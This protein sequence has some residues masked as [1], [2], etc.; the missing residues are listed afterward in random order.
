MSPS[1]Y[2]KMTTVGAD[3]R[4]SASPEPPLDATSTS[5]P[6][7]V[8]EATSAARSCASPSTTRMRAIYRSHLFCH[9]ARVL[10]PQR[11]RDTCS[12]ALRERVCHDDEPITT[13][14]LRERVTVLPHTS[15]RHV[16]CRSMHYGM[17]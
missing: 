15:R 16:P 9:H 8:S 14:A 17:T 1:A 5:W 11:F 2:S 6:S 13:H 3:A 4:A 10:P 7:C 12:R